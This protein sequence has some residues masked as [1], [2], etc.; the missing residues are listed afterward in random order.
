MRTLKPATPMLWI[1]MACLFAVYVV[2]A[3]GGDS[4][5]A[6]TPTLNIAGT[7]APTPAPGTPTPRPTMAPVPATDIPFPTPAASLT[8]APAPTTAPP[9]A[10]NTPLPTVVRTPSQAVQPVNGAPTSPSSTPPPVPTYTAALLE[11]HRENSRELLFP[12]FDHDAALLDDGRVLLGGGH[13]A[14]AN[15]NVIVPSP[16]GLVELYDPES[17]VWTVIDPVQGPG[18][19]YSLFRLP[20]GR[21]LALGVAASKDELKSMAAVFDSATGLWSELSGS[22]DVTRGSS[23]VFLLDDGR[24]LVA[25]GLNLFSDPSAGYSPAYLEA[26]EIFNPATGEWQRAASPSKRFQ[27]INVRQQPIFLQLADGRVAALGSVEAD[28]RVYL[29][30][31]EVYDPSTDTWSAIGGL[32]PFFEFRAGVALPDGRL[33]VHGEMLKSYPFRIYDPSND[34]WTPTGEP[35]YSRPLAIL[36]LLPDGRVLAAGGE[37]RSSDREKGRTIDDQAVYTSGAP[38][39]QPHSTTEIYDPQTNS[40]SLGPDLTEI[41]YGSTATVLLD[42]RVLLAGG[43]GI[44][45]EID[46]VYPLRTSEIVDANAPPGTPPGTSSQER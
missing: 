14:F 9:Q 5:P 41:R 33:L 4:P 7:S 3:C 29:P 19:M 42:G 13:T 45:L 21:L 8:Q 44:D 26:F 18:A 30:H 25:G 46:E 28:Q 17:D 35:L 31:A 37:E 6:A 15:N 40:W 43:I 16:L 34:T 38:L 20:D 22:P 39:D 27:P 36:A 12:R 24:V 10:S 32:D 1:G 23:A 11:Q 2:A